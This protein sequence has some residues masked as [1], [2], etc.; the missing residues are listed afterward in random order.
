VAGFRIDAAK[1]IQQVELD[2]IIG[3]VN[4]T[5]AGEGRPL[6]YV[7]LEVIGGAGEALSARDYFGVGYGTGGA[8]DITEFVFVGVG[9]KFR[10]VNGEFPA[11][12][13]P[14][15]PPGGQFSE[16]A[17]GLMASDKAVVFLQN[18]DTQH[19]CGI[20]YRDSDAFRLANVWMLAQPYGYPS[21]LSSYAFACPG[22]NAMG[23]PSDASGKT[24]DVTCA[25]S[26]ETATVGQWVCEHRDPAVAAMVGFRRAV[27]G[28]AIAGWWDNG[29]NAIAFSRGDRGF[30]ALNLEDSTVAVDAASP[31]A[32]GTYC[33]ALTGGLVAGACVGRSV[34]AGSGGVRLDLEAGRAVAI[35]AGTRVSST[36]RA[37]GGRV[38]WTN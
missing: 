29:A 24:N 2:A 25:T 19:Q 1:H 32:P 11:Q 27:A 15:G 8:A 26:F 17:W 38:A 35:H 13:D 36:V 5:L 22:G 20:G 16:A 18:H 37:T 31:L 33:D 14:A 6:P 28:S 3:R 34:T 12:L 21:V 9:N 30:V 10:R 7:F 4:R 23:P